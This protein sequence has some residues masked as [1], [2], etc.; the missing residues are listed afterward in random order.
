MSVNLSDIG[1]LN[2]KGFDYRCIIN[3]IIKDEAKKLLLVAN[4]TEES[5]ILYNIKIGLHI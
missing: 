2:I 4:L 1:I 3:L 5:R